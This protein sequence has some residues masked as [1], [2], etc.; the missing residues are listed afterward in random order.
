MP[1]KY[2]Q[3]GALGLKFACR[4]CGRGWGKGPAP[5]DVP[6]PLGGHGGQ[7]GLLLL[8]YPKENFF[9]LNVPLL[10]AGGDGG[11]GRPPWGR[12]AESGICWGHLPLQPSPKRAFFTF[13]WPPGLL[14]VVA[15]PGGGRTHLPVRGTGGDS[16]GRGVGEDLGAGAAQRQ[17]DLG[18]TQVVADGEAQL[19]ASDWGHQRA[20]GDTGAP[21][22]AKPPHPTPLPSPPA[23]P[24]APPAQRRGW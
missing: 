11:G 19:A 17:R 2:P 10:A 22:P 4:G 8:K 21:G 12:G 7:G 18:E 6:S 23:S 9:I 13:N 15:P 14:Q 3:K 1:L 24:P 16:E 5:G 20:V